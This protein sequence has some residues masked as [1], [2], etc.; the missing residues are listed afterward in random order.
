MR[1]ERPFKPSVLDKLIGGLARKKGDG[2]R[3]T[4]PCYVGSL[5]NFNE[6]ELRAVVIRDISWILNDVHFEAVV[7]LE[8]YPEIATSVVNQGIGDQTSLIVNSTGLARRAR[9]LADAVRAFEPRLLPD[10][11][12]V[13]YERTDVD[14]ENKLRF[15]IQGELKGAVDDR[16]VELKTAI[17]LDT[18]EVEVKG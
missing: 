17:A 15:T 12:R 9:S 10:S 18:G 5:D 16:Y 8:D 2:S 4:L 11:V 14:D 1:E 6:R 7:P 3:D 13:T